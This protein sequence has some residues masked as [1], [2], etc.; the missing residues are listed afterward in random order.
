M[1]AASGETFA[2][3]NPAREETIAHVARGGAED[4]DRAVKAARR[5]F[6]EGSWRRSNPSERGKLLWRIADRIEEHGEEFAQLES[7]DNGKP[8]AVAR[9]ADVALTVDHFRYYAGWA[10]KIEGETIP[11][12]GAERGDLPRLH[13]ARAG[14]RGGPDH[15]LELPAADGGVE[16]RGGAGLRQLRGA[17]AGRA[18][19]R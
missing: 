11:I 1:P 10:T 13:A 2:V 12:N 19:A 4:I 7:L 6:D 8:L 16:A 5:A 17:Q 18:D 9:A 15:P 14:G 3:E